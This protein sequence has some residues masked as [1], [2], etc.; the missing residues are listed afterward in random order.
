MG[1]V[2]QAEVSLALDHSST[3]FYA[4]PHS[5]GNVTHHANLALKRFSLAHGGIGG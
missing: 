4:R 2:R 5:I 1:N 3:Y